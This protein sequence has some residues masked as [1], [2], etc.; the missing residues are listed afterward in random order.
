MNL[1]RLSMFQG[2]THEFPKILFVGLHYIGAAMRGGG[3]PR[4]R[5]GWK[6]Q[7]ELGEQKGEDRTWLDVAGNSFYHGVFQSLEYSRS[8][9][10]LPDCAYSTPVCPTKL[11]PA[12]ISIG[13]IPR[14]AGK[15]S[16]CRTGVVYG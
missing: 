16:P 5:L 7:V 3:D 11:P 10:G 1:A 12:Q 9:H 8:P 4:R 6:G 14:Q 15:S 2:K 13:S